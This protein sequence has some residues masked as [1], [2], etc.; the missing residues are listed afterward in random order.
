MSHR[1]TQRITRRS[2]L[3]TAAAGTLTILPA[4]LAHGYSA[5]EKVKIGVV[6]AGIGAHN[7]ERLAAFGEEIA[8]LCEVDKGRLEHWGRSHPKA[9]LYTDYRKMI[10]SEKLDGIVVATPD[11]THANISIHAMREGLH[12]FCQKPLTHNVYEARLMA[13]VAAEKKLITQMGT[14]TQSSVEM[15]RTKELIQ[16]GALGGVTE[17][18]LGT[19][20]PIWLQG[21]D[22]PEGE[23]PLPPHLD[24]DLWLG[25]APRRPYKATWPKNHPAR[26]LA[27]FKHDFVYHPFVWR[28]WW[29]FGTGALGDIA[30]HAMNQ[31]YFALDLGAPSA[32]EVVATSGM[33][34]E[35]FPE[36]SILRFDFPARGNQPPVKVFWYDGGKVLPRELGGGLGPVYVGTKGSLPAGLGPFFG[37][38]VEPYARPTPGPWDREEVHKDWTRGIRTGKQP[39]CAF[40]YSGP[41][42][43]AYLL[44]NIALRVNQRIEWDA[45]AFRITN[46]QE[47]NQYL[48]REYRKGWEL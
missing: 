4:R 41:F 46:C 21:A 26:K 37:K 22:R 3:K 11:H 23:D 13:Q 39:G 38:K 43:E 1:L 5:N 34:R 15:L 33:T 8:A 16:S 18:H 2:C 28:G 17:V 31:V 42:T 36:W 6:G 35:M 45:K 24:W 10:E 29:D 12:C 25:P 19:N 32:V 40:G 7:A 44:G 47:A 20:R 48:K 9:R 14:D 27:S 30:P